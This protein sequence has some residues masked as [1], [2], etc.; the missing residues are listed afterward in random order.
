VSQSTIL[1]VDDDPLLREL[2]RDIGSKLPSYVFECVSSA[3]EGISVLECTPFDAVVTDLAMP[4]LNGVEFLAHVVRAQ[5]DSARI[6][7]SGH[8]D[9]LKIAECLSV[10][11]RYLN[12]P[13]D[14]RTLIALLQ[15]ITHFRGIISN[16]KLRSLLGSM[17]SLP[18]PPDAFVK[19]SQIIESPYSSVSDI[20]AEMERDAALT[21]KILRLV[22]SAQFGIQRKIVSPEEAIQILGVAFVRDLVLAIQTFTNFQKSPANYAVPSTVWEQS[23]RTSC[24]ARKLGRALGFSD[25]VCEQAFLAGLLHDVGK[26]ILITKAHEDYKSLL[27]YA[28]RFQLSASEAERRL[29]GVTHAQLGA[30]LLA[31]WGLPD[32]VVRIVEHHH[33]PSL[34]RDPS[35]IEPLLLVHVAQGLDDS[36][37]GKAQLDSA[38]LEKEGFPGGLDYWREQLNE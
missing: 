22:N 38:F 26:L 1:F 35:L 19:I 4:G 17:G 37:D 7:I 23:I 15:H 12:K 6:V 34:L 18:S 11:H 33:S 9:K 25:T 14:P 21:T 28:S 3:E 24:A 16:P 2:Y 27:D 32:E 36:R 31:L 30:Y 29:F 10:G 5:P 20:A 13:F 8:A